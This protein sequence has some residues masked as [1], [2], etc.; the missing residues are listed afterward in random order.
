LIFL[1]LEVISGLISQGILDV[2]NNYLFYNCI[3]Q[4]YTLITF[5]EV[6]NIEYSSDLYIKLEPYILIEK[7]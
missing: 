1:N 3:D 2:N 4:K 5:K 7:K 6:M